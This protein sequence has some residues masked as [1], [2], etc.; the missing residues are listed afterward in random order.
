MINKIILFVSVCFL[1]LSCTLSG[2][3][4]ISDYFIYFAL[5]FPC[6][7]IFFVKKNILINNYLL[8]Y[9]LLFPVLGAISGF[10]NSDLTVFFSSLI[11]FI[12][13]FLGF[14]IYP[15]VFKK[16]YA[17]LYIF[18]Y[19]T[20]LSFFII[21]Y[22][23]SFD[24]NIVAPYK[25]IYENPNSFG[26][27]TASISI[28]ILS[29]LFGYLE[30]KGHSIRKLFFLISFSL[31][32]Y[33][34]LYS[35]SRT[36]VVAIIVSFILLV[37]IYFYKNKISFIKSICWFF[38]FIVFFVYM[39]DILE[40]NILQKFSN[41]YDG[42]DLFDGRGYIWEVTFNNAG[43]FGNGSDYFSKT[44]AL[45]PHNSFV[46]ILGRLGYLFTFAFVILW[47]WI[48]YISYMYTINNK[49]KYSYMYFG[50]WLGFLILSTTE[51]MLFRFLMVISVMYIG[52]ILLKNRSF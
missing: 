32:F 16:T 30:E 35:G 13:F 25:S 41:K 17:E 14:F 6:L 22:L 52:C 1:V 5:L 42:D 46:S 9:L 11:F 24:L 49:Y 31:T 19:S 40:E 50:G 15:Y 33:L 27:A 43:I 36:S 51:V 44:F 26:V 10:L 28:T 45:G 48:G 21:C 7:A 39:R 38:T 23:I 20:I 37:F 4:L 2:T 18:E 12:L 29:L 8:C 34:T 47:G 3:L